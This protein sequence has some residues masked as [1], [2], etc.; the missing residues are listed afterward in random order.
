MTNEDN[1]K[2]RKESEKVAEGLTSD[3]LDLFTDAGLPDLHSGHLPA[4]SACLSA[5]HSILI[6]M[7]CIT[8]RGIAATHLRETFPAVID[9][10]MQKAE[11][12]DRKSSAHLH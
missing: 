11:A 5:I 2:L 7:D 8:C 1:D 3:I 10:A 9:S 6:G 4:L 12:L